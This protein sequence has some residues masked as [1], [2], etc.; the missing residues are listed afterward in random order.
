MRR[1]RSTTDDSG[2]A[3]VL[4][5]VLVGALVTITTLVAVVG[6][7]VT[8]HRRLESAV[9]LGALAGASAVQRGEDACVAAGSVTARNGAVLTDCSVVGQIVTV[10]ARRVTDEVLGLEFT[11]TATARG[12]PASAVAAA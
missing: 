10:R 8:D 9:D 12:G 6:G 7:A 3:A 5:T 1:G 11:L 2:S 4:A